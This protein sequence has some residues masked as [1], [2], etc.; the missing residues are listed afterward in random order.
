MH[1]FPIGLPSHDLD[2]MEVLCVMVNPNNSVVTS[3]PWKHMHTLISYTMV[4]MCRSDN[5][6]QTSAFFFHR[7]IQGSNLGH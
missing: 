3:V 6:F 2:S 5:C 1:E 7:G 4:H